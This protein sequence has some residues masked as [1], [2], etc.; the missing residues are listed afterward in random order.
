MRH[1][2]RRD[3]RPVFRQPDFAGVAL[4]KTVASAENQISVRHPFLQTL[5]VGK[6]V[7]DVNPGGSFPEQ[8]TSAMTEHIRQI[9]VNENRIDRLGIMAQSLRQRDE[10]NRFEHG[11]HVRF[12]ISNRVH[13]VTV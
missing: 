10:I 6:D 11:F 3:Q 8:L 2:G 13:A 5:R 1:T 12:G 9:A 4:E 7:I